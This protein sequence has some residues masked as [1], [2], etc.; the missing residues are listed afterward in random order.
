[1]YCVEVRIHYQ[2]VATAACDW[3]CYSR[4]HVQLL[5][6]SLTRKYCRLDLMHVP[7][8]PGGLTLLGGVVMTFPVDLGSDIATFDIMFK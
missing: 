8:D 6:S 3:Y 1:M 7:H 4:L 2:Q 5:C